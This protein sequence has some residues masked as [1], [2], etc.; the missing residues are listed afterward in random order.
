MGK[1]NIFVN[2]LP[3]KKLHFQISALDQ[4]A[5][6]DVFPQTLSWYWEI[7]QISNLCTG[8][9]M[10]IPPLYRFAICKYQ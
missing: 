5:A 9:I 2:R 4:A 1:N 10:N 8:I 7:L 3:R 6:G